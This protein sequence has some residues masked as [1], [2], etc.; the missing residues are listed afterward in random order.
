MDE[1]NMHNLF[2]KV[3]K[4]KKD[5]ICI[6]TSFRFLQI[7]DITRTE[8]FEQNF[9][10]QNMAGLI[11][12]TKNPSPCLNPSVYFPK[13]CHH[14][15]PSLFLHH[16]IE[17]YHIPTC[18]CTSILHACEMC[19]FFSIA[20]I[21]ILLSPTDHLLQQLSPLQEQQ[22]RRD[23]DPCWRRP[24]TWDPQTCCWWQGQQGDADVVCFGYV[25]IVDWG[26]CTLYRVDFLTVPPNFQHQNDKWWAANQRFCS[27]N[28]SMYKRSLSV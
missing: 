6:W 14:I 25:P 1:K 12:E 20:F 10:L 3:S 9:C 4:T 26:R 7:D 17:F 18:E 11:E 16:F 19:M 2:L 28:F 21:S 22:A 15:A 8:R 13:S 27:M 5:H 24:W 23:G